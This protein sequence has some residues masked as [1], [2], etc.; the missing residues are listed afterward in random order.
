MKA[1]WHDHES[2]SPLS[3][4]FSSQDDAKSFTRFVGPLSPLPHRENSTSEVKAS[5]TTKV[6]DLDEEIP[7]CMEDKDCFED[8]QDVYDQLYTCDSSS[9]KRPSS[10]LGQ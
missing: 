7:T 5:P 9:N 1:R 6:L 10:G 8:I 2:E 3:D 4:D